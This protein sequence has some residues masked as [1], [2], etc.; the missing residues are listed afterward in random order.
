MK[1]GPITRFRVIGPIFVELIYISLE[2][3]KTNSSFI[4]GYKN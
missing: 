3:L 4:I 2:F 1:I